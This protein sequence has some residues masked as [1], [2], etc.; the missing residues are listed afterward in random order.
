MSHLCPPIPFEL[1]HPAQPIDRVPLPG[2]LI[3]SASSEYCIA[4]YLVASYPGYRLDVSL[5]R[6]FPCDA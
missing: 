3:A 1:F 6:T 5:A 2:S 4:G